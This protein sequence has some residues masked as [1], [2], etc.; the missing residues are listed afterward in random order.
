MGSG[1]GDHREEMLEKELLRGSWLGSYSLW[2]TKT[3]GVK[4][5]TQKEKVPKGGLLRRSW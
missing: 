1:R 3:D 2:E 4:N 5:S